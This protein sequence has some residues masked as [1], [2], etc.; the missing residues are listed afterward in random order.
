M[1]SPPNNEKK[2]GEQDET[3]A[4]GHE[5]AFKSFKME[6]IVTR[7]QPRSNTEQLQVT[8]SY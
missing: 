3:E 7:K 1:D 4:I 5:I 8:K 2:Q 6:P